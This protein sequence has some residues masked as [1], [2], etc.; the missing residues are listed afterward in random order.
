MTI[1]QACPS[2]HEALA[3][4]LC[5]KEAAAFSWLSRLTDLRHPHKLISGHLRVKLHI[6]YVSIL[7][8]YGVLKSS[9]SYLQ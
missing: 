7:T 6:F 1:W 3:L 2:I 4:S 9:A 5:H 8:D